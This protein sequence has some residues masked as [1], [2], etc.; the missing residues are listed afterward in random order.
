MSSYFSW[1]GGNAAFGSAA[2]WKNQTTP[3]QTGKSSPTAADSVDFPLLASGASTITGTGAAG[4]MTVEGSITIA[5]T[6]ATTNT[7]NAGQ[8]LLNSGS[9]TA[10]NNFINSGTTTLAGGYLMATYVTNTGTMNVGLSSATISGF[11]ADNGALNIGAK[12]WLNGTA[13]MAIGNGQSGSLAVTAGGVV[14]TSYGIMGA[15]AGSTGAAT[16]SGASSVWWNSNDLTVGQLAG[17]SLTAAGGGLVAAQ[18]LNVATGSGVTATLAVTGAGSEI[19][20]MQSAWI[21]EAGTGALAVTNGGLFYVGNSLSLATQ[22][23][24]KATLQASG[25]GSTIGVA[26]SLIVADAGAASLSVAG[27]AYGY[28]NTLIAG[29]AKGASGAIDVSGA[30]SALVAWQSMLIGQSG[31]GSLIV[32]QGATATTATSLVL[33]DYSGATGSASVQG[34]GS[35]FQAWS[36][37]VVGAAGAGTLSVSAGGAVAANAVAIANSAGSTGKLLLTGAGSSLTAAAITIGGGWS[38]A[39][40]TG[41][42]TIALGAQLASTGW[43]ILWNTGALALA[44]GSA[45]AATYSIGGTLSGY[46]AITATSTSAAYEILNSGKIEANGGILTLNGAV[47]QTG[48]LAID[49][50]S[51]LLLENS[52]ASTQTVIFNPGGG[53]TL[54]LAS[55]ATM[56]ASIT[57]FGAGDSIA[58]LGSTITQLLYTQGNLVALGNT[59]PSGTLRAVATLQLTGAYSLSNFAFT[60]GADGAATI[61]YTT[62]PTT[63]TTGTTTTGSTATSESTYL[64]THR[65]FTDASVWNTVISATTATLAIPTVNAAVAGLTT[66]SAGGGNVA[67][68]YAQATDPV[69]AVLYNPNTYAEVSAGAWLRSGNT[70]AAEQQILSTSS[71]TNPLPGNPYSTDVV[72][73]AWN[74][75]P[76]G[77][78]A[79]YDSWSQGAGQTLY[80]HVPAGALPT[81]SAD[82]QTV[83]IQPDGTAIE[84][85]APIVLSSGTWVSSMFS[86]TNAATASGTGADNGRTA[87]MIENYAGVLRDT[88]VTS[89]AI[90]HALALVVPQSMLQA[91]V[92]GPALTFDTNS[93][94]YTGTLPMGAHLALPASLDLT[95]L[96]LQTALGL[97]IAQ[98]AKTYGQ[99]IVDTGGTGISIV[100]QNT[101]TSPALATYSTALQSDLN[102]IFHHE[103]LVA[104]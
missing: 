59:G 15:A 99:F 82:G 9:L 23:T 39:G 78:P 104:S 44:G 19:Y 89:G 29:N 68:Y 101:P 75:T 35:K 76:S 46:G 93:A 80:I 73:E 88:D 5:A 57:G 33:G 94:G 40:G 53:A 30:G 54:A 71:A 52:V 12:G 64:Q 18:T 37:I 45:T 84:L 28:A 56:A 3:A 43:T 95:A 27:G 98:A 60:N 14:T 1:L 6:I 51:E 16:V 20:A 50:Q 22:P 7:T 10:S 81:N 77:L 8:I 55:P 2:A 42:A 72:G 70:A 26:Q 61:T 34:A 102:T 13:G 96:H 85:Y 11:F 97:E 41:T 86:A 38:A 65:F 91:A 92:T 90:N 69:V 58:L 62:T 66:W 47:T 63:P 87:S 67:I 48:S 4:G 36:S 31:A 49:A 21:G 17:A 100:T 32:E 103:V 83:I 74:T 79:T 24:G 25:S